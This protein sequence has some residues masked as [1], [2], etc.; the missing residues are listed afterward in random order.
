[1]LYALSAAGSHQQPGL[2]YKDFA[3]TARRAQVCKSCL[4]GQGEYF[5]QEDRAH[6]GFQR[7]T[8]LRPSAPQD[9]GKHSKELCNVF[10]AIPSSGVCKAP[11]GGEASATDELEH[12]SQVQSLPNPYFGT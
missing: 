10:Q 2:L 3:R 12:V 7:K 11:G 1:M 5:K 8:D 4:S 9:A 6:L